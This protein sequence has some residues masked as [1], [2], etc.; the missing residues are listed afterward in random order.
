MD[1]RPPE[2]LHG[3]MVTL[4][5]FRLDDAPAVRVAIA[6][7][8]ETLRQWMP[9]AQVPPTEESVLAFLVPAAEQFGGTS[10]ADFAIILREAGQYV[11]SCGMMPRIGPGAVEIGYWVHT[12]FHRRGIASEAARLVTNA[13]LAVPGITSVEIHCDEA[14]IAS[15]GVA[16][17]L[18]FRLDRIEA[19][20]PGAPGEIGRSMIWVTAS[21]V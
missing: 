11:G 15:Q 6:S 2:A 21:P 14:N 4:R 3:P 10:A 7:S 19:G 12:A 13:A 20:T 1:L 16:R 9:W 17:S 8:F 18:G 5:R